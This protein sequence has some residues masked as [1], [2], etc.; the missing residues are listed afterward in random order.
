MSDLRF[1]TAAELQVELGALWN[2]WG[3]PAASDQKLLR[4]VEAGL[5]T[6]VVD[7]LLAA[8]PSRLQPG[9]SS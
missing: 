8:A 2:G 6:N 7:R 3:P 5:N 1:K 4:L 9:L